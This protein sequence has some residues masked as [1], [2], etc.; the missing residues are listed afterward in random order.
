MKNGQIFAHKSTA[1]GRLDLEYLDETSR[2]KVSLRNPVEREQG[3]GRKLKDFI[4]YASKESLAQVHVGGFFHHEIRRNS[5]GSSTAPMQ[6][7]NEERK[8]RITETWQHHLE[9][10]PSPAKRPVI[11]HRLIFSMSGEQYTAL[12]AAGINPDQVLHSSLKRVMRKF[13]E[14]FHPRDSIGYAYGFHHDTGHLHVDVALCPRTA[15]GNYVGCSTSR[16][17]SSKHKRQMD[18]IR[19]W[20]EQENHRW[21]N[22]LVSPQKIALTIS[23]RLDSDK[24][25]I[26]PPLNH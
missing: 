13:G 23:R 1:R 10:F 25:L 6:L 4:D 11:A 8:R 19:G 16:T 18:Q 24:M 3:I 9:K 17:T 26:A 15:K 21:E 20:F 22:A 2:R 14:K 12:V 7:S 5:D